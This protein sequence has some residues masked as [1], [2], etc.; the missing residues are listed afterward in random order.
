MPR[1]PLLFGKIEDDTDDGLLPRRIRD[2]LGADYIPG[3]SEIVMANDLS[4]SE[5]ISSSVKDKY[6]RRD[7]G[8][9][10]SELPYEFK[11]V[12]TTGPTGEMSHTA[13]ED[14]YH[15]K[16]LGYHPVV[17]E[18]P[19]D[20]TTRFGFGFPPAARIAPDGM[21]RHRDVALFYVDRQTADRLEEERMAE[22]RRVLGN[23][24]PGGE[25]PRDL[26]DFEEEDSFTASV[27]ATHNHN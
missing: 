15:Y 10:P 4:H 6:Y 24:Q 16:K 13:D 3:Y 5:V 27:S 26:Y 21:I 11:W 2:K 9:G 12:R 22:N 18:S 19:D 23:N 17:V 1:K 25:R 14:A 20:F 7:F 8:V